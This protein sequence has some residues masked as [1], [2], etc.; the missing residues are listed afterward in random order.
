M[1]FYLR[2]YG[3]LRKYAIR[4]LNYFDISENLKEYF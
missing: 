4:L 1:A 3:V 2:C